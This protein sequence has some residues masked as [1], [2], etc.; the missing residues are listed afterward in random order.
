[1]SRLRACFKYAAGEDVD[2]VVQDPGAA[3]LVVLFGSMSFE[4]SLAKV[5]EV[6]TQHEWPEEHSFTWS[7]FCL[8]AKGLGMLGEE[9]GADVEREMSDGEGTDQNAV[10]FTGYAKEDTMGE[11]LVDN[12]ITADFREQV[13]KVLV[14]AGQDNATSNFEFPL[15]TK[16]GQRIIVLLNATPRLDAAGRVVGVVGIGQDI[17]ELNKKQ[18]ELRA[19]K[20]DFTSP[21]ERYFGERKWDG[22][23]KG[24]TREYLNFLHSRDHNKW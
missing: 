18:E 23:N 22:K 19:I 17:S 7:D 2:G 20:D 6:M 12:F 13:Q 1:M 8:L 15:D 16:S 21:I 5:L 11:L 4:V 14:Q 3:G 9:G 24:I 10:A